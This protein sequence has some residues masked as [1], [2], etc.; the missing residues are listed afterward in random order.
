MP[1]K[2]IFSRIK[3]QVARLEGIVDD[4]LDISKIQAGKLDLDF[5]KT[6]L[7]NLIKES[8][9]AVQ[10]NDHILTVDQ[11]AEDQLLNLDRQKMIQVLV[12]LLTNAIKYSEPHTTIA[13][14]ALIVGDEVQI[15]VA[16]QGPGIPEEHLTNIFNQYYRV[17]STA[18]KT[19]GMGLGLYICREIIEAHAGSIWAESEMGKGSVFYLRVPVENRK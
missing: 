7:L 14:Q 6:S 17:S 2:T 11:P 19:K 9:D 8:V 18:G 13:L 3:K 5:Q 4:L 16:D 10:W 12:N 15:S 1:P